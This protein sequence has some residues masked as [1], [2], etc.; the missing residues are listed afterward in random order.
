MRN[1]EEQVKRLSALGDSQLRNGS[2]ASPGS[3]LHP[4]EQRSDVTPSY[5]DLQ[6]QDSSVADA[7][8]PASARSRQ[9]AGQE[10]SGINRHTRNVEFYGSSSSVALLSHVQRAGDEPVVSTEETDAGALVS[11]LHNPAFSPSRGNVLSGHVTHHPQC[12]GFLASFFTSIHYVHPILDRGEFFARCEKLW[13]GEDA[14]LE[15][16][17]FAALYYSI[18]SLGALVRPKDE[19]LLEGTDNLQWSRKFFDESINRC[20]RLGMV[21]D[22]DMVQCYFVLVSIYISS[23]LE[24]S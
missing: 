2:E 18:L 6:R 14:A 16:S 4:N 21:T 12:Q 7:D 24:L 9:T 20:N 10:V 15:T 13:T 1:L 19:E 3:S 5:V 23:L 17:S 22:L 8:S 11:N